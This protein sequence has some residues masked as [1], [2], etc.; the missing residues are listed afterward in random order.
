MP[1]DYLLRLARQVGQLFSSLIAKRKEGRL[2]EAQAEIERLCLE[3]VGLPWRTIRG[4]SPEG[5]LEHVRNAG[6]L[7]HHR[8]VILGELLIEEAELA[9]VEGRAQDAIR[10]RLQAFCLISDVL[11]MLSVDDLLHYREKLEGLA[12]Q[13][14]PMA[15]HPYVGEKLRYY[16]EKLGKSA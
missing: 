14:A 2:E 12:G 13:L 11:D 16:R 10:A 3:H 8:A 5:L 1:E 15:A 7:R 4:S 6:A 9:V